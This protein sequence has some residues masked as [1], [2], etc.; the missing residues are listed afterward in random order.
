MIGQI[1]SYFAGKKVIKDQQKLADEQRRMGE[2]AISKAESIW[3]DYDTPAGID[4]NVWD[5]QSALNARSNLYALMQEQ[6]GGQQANQLQNVRNAA[7]SG[8]EALA[9]SSAVGINAQKQMREAAIAAEEERLRRQQMLYGA[10]TAQAEYQDKEWETNINQ[11]YLQKLQ[12]GQDLI[13]AGIQNKFDAKSNLAKLYQGV[14]EG[15]DSFISSAI[16]TGGGFL[17]SLFKGGSNT[18]I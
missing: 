14:G 2:Q 17:K 10:R 3:K 18:V 6:I 16:P 4:Q 1:F 13:G 5:A 9:A 12:E 7:S 15:I 11:R 8:A